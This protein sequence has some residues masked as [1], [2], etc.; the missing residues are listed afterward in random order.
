MRRLGNC[1][2]ANK[3]KK[4]I[5]LKPYFFVFSSTL[6]VCDSAKS[7]MNVAL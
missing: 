6:A 7:A 1:V 2:E 3:I 4:F 5:L